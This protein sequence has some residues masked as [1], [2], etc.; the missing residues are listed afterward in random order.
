[1]RPATA[2]KAARI[3]QDSH[4]APALGEEGDVFRPPLSSGHLDEPDQR[5]SPHGNS[6]PEGKETGAGPQLGVV[7]QVP[8]LPH[9]KGRK[10]HETKRRSLVNPLHFSLP[11]PLHYATHPLTRELTEQAGS[12]TANHS[13]LFLF[14]PSPATSDAAF[15][16]PE[17]LMKIEGR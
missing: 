3:G 5:E 13:I 1:M 15:R 2:T 6:Q 17:S 9:D 8:G 7:H 11:P 16:S 10:R 12:S 4:D 14:Q